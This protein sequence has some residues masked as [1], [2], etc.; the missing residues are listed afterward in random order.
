MLKSN[1]TTTTTLHQVP[2]SDSQGHSLATAVHSHSS[3]QNISIGHRGILLSPQQAHS[4]HQHQIMAG[5]TA[6]LPRSNGG[7]GVSTLPKPPPPPRSFSNFST[8]PHKITS[9]HS[10]Q[11][12]QQQQHLHHQ[13]QQQHQQHQQQ[14]FQ[15]YTTFDELKV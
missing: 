10:Q 13:Q 1:S 5:A 7:V 15:S 9:H 12:Q 8:L 4:H 6:T 2:Q 3:H 14:Q 11:Q